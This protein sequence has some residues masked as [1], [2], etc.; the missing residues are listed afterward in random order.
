MQKVPDFFAVEEEK[1]KQV[2][3]NDRE[4]IVLKEI[5]VLV[6][7]KLLVF[8][9]GIGFVKAFFDKRPFTTNGIQCMDAIRRKVDLYFDIGL[10]IVG[11][12]RIMVDQLFDSCGIAVVFILKAEAL[13]TI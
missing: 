9:H 3:R 11:Q 12:E 13:G 8:I 1:V 2:G 5:Q 7:K 10:N 6:G 4:Q